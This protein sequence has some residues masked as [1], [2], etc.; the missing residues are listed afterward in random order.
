MN[1]PFLL[2][3]PSVIYLF[4]SSHLAEYLQWMIWGTP[5]DFL[6]INLYRVFFVYICNFTNKSKKKLKIGY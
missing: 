1:L 5:F 4:P 6:G 2:L 3:K